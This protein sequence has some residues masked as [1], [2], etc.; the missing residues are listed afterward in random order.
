MKSTAPKPETLELQ[1][2]VDALREW[3]GKR[4]LY[5]DHT[6]DVQNSPR[7]FYVSH[8][9]DGHRRRMPTTET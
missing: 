7:R 5:N 1:A 6:R 9:G 2:F 8:A 3:M 4:P